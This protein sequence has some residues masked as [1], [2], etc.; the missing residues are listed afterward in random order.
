MYIDQN[1]KVVGLIGYPL[2][3]SFSPAMHNAA[4]QS[5]QLNYVYVPLPVTPGRL[6]DAVAG[7]KA[8]NFIG[9][10]VTLPHK[11][12]IIPFLDFVTEEA[13]LAGAVNTLFWTE[14]GYMVGDSTDVEGFKRTLKE[15]RIEVQGQTVTIIGAGGAAR[16]LAVS[17][18]RMGA[19][20]IIFLSRRFDH[21]QR[22]LKEL[23][24]LFRKTTWGSHTRTN[25]EF[26]TDLSRTYLLINAS[27]VGMFPQNESTPV[28]QQMLNVM[29]DGAH[30]YD[31][32]YNPV[33]TL[34]LKQAKQLGRLKTFGGLE[35]LA[36]QGAVSFERWTGKIPPVPVML[37]ALRRQLTFYN[38]SAFK[39]VIQTSAIPVEVEPIPDMAPPPKAKASAP[40]SGGEKRAFDATI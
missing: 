14:D 34:L 40:P 8:M 23:K 36:Y 20:E 32:V 17:L 3:H 12:E 5:L 2:E 29:P 38:T 26:V 21:I 1:T 13:K 11:E 28:P 33:D 35:M 31:L 27:P 15:F 16:A 25:T 4:F 9:G 24:P 10:N 22:L 30:V 18:C 6:R 39:E 37:N 19:K 7:M